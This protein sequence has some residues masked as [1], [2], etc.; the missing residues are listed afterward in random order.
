MRARLHVPRP[1]ARPGE[2]PD[3]S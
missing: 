3:F 2:A 1:P